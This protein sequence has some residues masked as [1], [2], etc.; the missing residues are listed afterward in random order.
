VTWITHQTTKSQN[1][2]VC[3]W[4]FAFETRWVNLSFTFYL[5][6]I[7]T[8]MKLVVEL[9]HN[10]W[11]GRKIWRAIASLEIFLRPPR[12]L[13]KS[14]FRGSECFFL[15]QFHYKK[16]LANCNKAS[17]KKSSAHHR[18][19]SPLNRPTPDFYIAIWP[20][21]DNLAISGGLLQAPLSPLK[22]D[23]S[24]GPPGLSDGPGPLG[25][26]RNSTTVWNYIR[27]CSD[28]SGMCSTERPTW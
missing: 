1:D 18:N 24:R 28:L 11:G 10:L 19:C 15:L 26:H 20:M 17:I 9:Q 14:H 4:W 22:T 12:P 7:W 2:N 5:S 25:P 3:C 8:D 16:A 21:G 27:G 23:V 6:C 13:Q